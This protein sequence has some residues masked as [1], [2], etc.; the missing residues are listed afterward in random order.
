MKRKY[1]WLV[2]GLLIIASCKVTKPYQQPS[3]DN[4]DYIAIMLA[5]ILA[6]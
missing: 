2:P 5:A 3:A 1:S 4:R 6:V